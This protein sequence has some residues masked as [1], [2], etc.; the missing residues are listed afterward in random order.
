M[1]DSMEKKS[2]FTMAAYAA[3]GM[4]DQEI[5][6]H[7]ETSIAKYRQAEANKKD[8]EEMDA[9]FSEISV[10]SYI[11]V[12]RIIDL[13]A[14]EVIADMKDVENVVKLIKPNKS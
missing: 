1:S 11:N 9:I 14:S 10:L 5:V 3:E 7:L 6:N 2:F 8:K 12:V 4:S 13:K